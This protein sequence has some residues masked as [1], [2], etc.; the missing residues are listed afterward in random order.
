ML[1]TYIRFRRLTKSNCMEKPRQVI[2]M[3]NLQPSPRCLPY[4]L[5]CHQLLRI[6]VQA[7]VTGTEGDFSLPP[8]INIVHLYIYIHAAV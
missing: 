8:G 4:L 6:P 5:Q 7:E 2:S 3:S 1:D